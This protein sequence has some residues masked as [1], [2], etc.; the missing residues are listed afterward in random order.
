MIN[1]SQ[2]NRIDEPPQKN[3]QPRLRVGV[4]FNARPEQGG[5]YQYALTL[6]DC[7]AHHIPDFDFILY[8]AN[9]DES[10]LLL[11]VKRIPPHATPSAE[12]TQQDP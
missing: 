11:G 4:Y 3:V 12:G 7:L 10:A 8:H 2:N 6:I 5:L 1:K 9:L